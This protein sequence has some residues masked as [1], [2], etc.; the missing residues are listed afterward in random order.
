MIIL[1]F[2][3]HKSSTVRQLSFNFLDEIQE[4]HEI[5]KQILFRS[6][7][8]NQRFYLQLTVY[9]RSVYIVLLK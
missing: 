6:G 1:S 5:F 2:N 9:C 7:K 4:P 3:Y 8:S